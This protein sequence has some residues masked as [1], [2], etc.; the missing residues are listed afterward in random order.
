LVQLIKRGAVLFSAL[1]V[2]FL[3]IGSIGVLVDALSRSFLNAPIQGATEMFKL[4]V[5][6]SISALI[7]HSLIERQHIAIEFLGT[8]LGHRGRH[9]LA[10]VS[11]V[12]VL[13]TFVALFWQLIGHTMELQS[14]GETTMVLQLS[15][16]PWWWVVVAIIAFSAVCQAVVAW[17]TVF[18]KRLSASPGVR[19]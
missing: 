19:S 5:I 13:A 12:L 15:L 7:P 9:I 14:G 16:A 17:E 1:G 11:S 4:V 6:V 10:A 2:G 18:D 8:A 3:F